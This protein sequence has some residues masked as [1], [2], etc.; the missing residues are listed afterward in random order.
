[1]N[2][3]RKKEYRLTISD[4]QRKKHLEYLR[5]IYHNLTPEKKAELL[6]KRKANYQANKQ[7]KINGIF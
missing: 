6:A 3:E 7:K 2:A 1:M 5:N 4:Y